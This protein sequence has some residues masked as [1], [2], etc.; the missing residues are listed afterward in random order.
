MA[1]SLHFSDAELACRGKNCCWR[2]NLCKPELLKALEELRELVGKPIEI[3]SAYRCA[4]HNRAIGGAP[5][6]QH[7]E[8]IAADIAV[9]GMTTSALEFMVRKIA[10]FNG[11]G[12][13]D[14]G[15]YVHA[16]TRKSPAQWCYDE[17]GQACSYYP[18]NAT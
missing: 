7:V 13:D 8:G 15:G 3:R 2:A 17:K 1:N 9:K 10:A 14:R 5:K 16:D 12:R 18:P 11:V 4:K 6:S